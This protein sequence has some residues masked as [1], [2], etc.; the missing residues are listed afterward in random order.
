MM[1]DLAVEGG[2]R[3]KSERQFDV[4]AEKSAGLVCSDGETGRRLHCIALPRSE[5]STIL[6]HKDDLAA[7]LEESVAPHNVVA[8]AR[9]DDICVRMSGDFIVNIDET[10]AVSF[11]PRQETRGNPSNQSPRTNNIGET[12]PFLRVGR[13]DLHGPHPAHLV[14]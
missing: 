6:E 1:S 9:T 14:S 2:R 3:R 12:Q 11:L 4:G 13:L 7:F 10:G 8:A 5:P